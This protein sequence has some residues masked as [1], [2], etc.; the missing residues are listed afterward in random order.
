MPELKRNILNFGYRITFK[1]GGMLSHSFHTFHVVT[2]CVL[3]AIEDLKP[4]PIKFGS[5]CS[6]LDVDI[7]K[8][9]FPTQYLPNIKKLCKKIILFIDFYKKQIDYYNLTAY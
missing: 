2:K 3:L 1:Y 9:N 4:L 8:S 5:T 7:N 6:Y